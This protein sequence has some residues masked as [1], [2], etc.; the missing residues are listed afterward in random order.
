MS[1]D[2]YKALV[3][4]SSRIKRMR[5]CSELWMFANRKVVFSKP[6]QSFVIGKPWSWET[7]TKY[8][9]I[10]LYLSS[11]SIAKIEK[12]KYIKKIRLNGMQVKWN[13]FGNKG[14]IKIE[15]YFQKR[16]T[17]LPDFNGTFCVIVNV[18][19][20]SFIRIY[21]R[22]MK[23]QCV[24]YACGHIIILFFLFSQFP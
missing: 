8:S 12:N 5:I 2:P 7:K 10:K 19:Y 21:S 1:L 24:T 22:K 15:K 17:V 14:A 4:K 6:K 3:K 23:C 18:K 13:G 11:Q 16:Q 9:W 20:D